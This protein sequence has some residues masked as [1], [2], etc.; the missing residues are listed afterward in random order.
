M[1]NDLPHSREGNGRGSISQVHYENLVDAK[2][3]QILNS[4]ENSI[5][6]VHAAQRCPTFN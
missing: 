5:C 2:I 6:L 4:G 1:A 3:Y